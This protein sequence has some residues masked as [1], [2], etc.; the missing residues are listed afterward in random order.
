MTGSNRCH[1]VRQ[2]MFNSDSYVPTISKRYFI[3]VA[4]FGRSQLPRVYTE[5]I[6]P[7]S[8]IVSRLVS[9]RLPVDVVQRNNIKHAVLRTGGCLQSDD[10]WSNSG[11]NKTI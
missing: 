9:D 4:T 10:Y 2:V 8:N 7:G 3:D 5:N 6:F 1:C 11:R